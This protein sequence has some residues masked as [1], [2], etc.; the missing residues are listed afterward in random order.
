MDFF[1]HYERAQVFLARQPTYLDLFTKIAVL[2]LVQPQ[3]DNM[4]AS[5]HSGG[6]GITPKV[7]LDIQTLCLRIQRACEGATL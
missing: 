4:T 7:R 1:A 3:R 5:A 6:L 2:A